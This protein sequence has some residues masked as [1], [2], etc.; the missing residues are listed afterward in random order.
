MKVD[1]IK[2]E[3]VRKIKIVTITKENPEYIPKGMFVCHKS[4]ILRDTAW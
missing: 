1:L 4:P 2:D 3:D